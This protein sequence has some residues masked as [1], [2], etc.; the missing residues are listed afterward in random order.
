M[1]AVP[2]AAIGAV[3]FAVRPDQDMADGWWIPALLIAAVALLVGLL[4]V[5]GLWLIV[6]ARSGRRHRT[7][8]VAFDDL[9]TPYERVAAACALHGVELSESDTGW[10]PRWRARRAAGP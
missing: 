5:L 3:G 7:T 8:F 2:A 4:G 9:A 6:V 1:L 10:W